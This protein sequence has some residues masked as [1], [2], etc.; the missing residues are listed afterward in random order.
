M[1]SPILLR[2]LLLIGSVLGV[3]LFGWAAMPIRAAK[4]P[5]GK[6]DYNFHVRPILA[7]RCFVCHGP[8]EK[9]RKAKL[10]LDL[11]EVAFARQAVVPGKPEESEV[12]ERITADGSRRMPPRKSNLTLSKDEIEVLRRWIAE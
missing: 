9:N 8:D 12:M 4:P 2:R 7:D 5:P 10:R 3:A 11:A 6:L 1:P